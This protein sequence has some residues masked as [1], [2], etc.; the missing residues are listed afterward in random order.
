VFQRIADFFEWLDTQRTAHAYSVS[1]ARLDELPGWHIEAGTGTI[2]H[3][4]GRFFSV[5]GLEV[6]TDHAPA[7]SWAQPIIV[8][9]EVGIL[10]ILVKR[11]RGVQHFLMQAK[12]EPGNID[13]LQLSPT[14][15]ATR[16]NYTK[17]HKGRSVPYLEY[18]R[19]P[20]RGRVLSDVLQ[21]E[22]GSWFLHKR[23]RNMIIEIAEDV[24]VL[25]GFCWLNKAQLA[26]LMRWDHVVNMDSRT[27]LAGF[28]HAESHRQE[29]SDLDRDSLVELLS[30][31]TEAK[32][33]YRLTRERVPLTAV[34][35]WVVSPER[36]SHESDNYFSV[37]GVHVE[38]S[39][40]EIAGWSQPM[41][42][43]RHPGVVAFVVRHTGGEPEVLVR[44]HT[45]AGTL[46][47]VEM[48][49]TVQ[50]APR[51]YADLPASR[52]PPYL[53]HVLSAR[54]EQVL[55]DARHSEEGGR[56]FQ[57]E[58]RYL[59]VEAGADFPARLD[60]DFAWAT[61]PQLAE[62]ARYGNYVNVEAR[63]LLACLLFL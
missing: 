38:A 56:F 59:I 2:R 16:S 22:Q 35:N 23:N 58:N 30:W 40:R 28:P 60:P 51:N 63:N 5:E 61:I 14:V 42:Q 29:D 36:I 41:I 57:A 11:F 7:P 20:R 50:C 25:D 53:D 27:V 8:Q 21:S 17:V 55:F 62:L 46:D 44:A 43:P 45:Q 47:V 48:A 33:R 39:S 9:P 18:F 37:M 12:M 13:L 26:E 52:Q 49:P 4:S 31:F 15:Q 34:K 54:P 3:D 10:G 6:E 1:H 24:E 19:A 32:S